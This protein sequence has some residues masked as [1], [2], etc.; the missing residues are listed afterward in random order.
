MGMS[1]DEYLDLISSP[2]PVSVG[3]LSALDRKGIDAGRALPGMTKRGVLAALGYPARHRTPSVESD[4]W[5]YWTNR[6]KT[7][8]VEFD[9]NGE[10][11]RVTD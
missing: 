1:V 9:A 6:F 4:R 10:V 7:R 8:A 5:I 3:G 11:A 2:D